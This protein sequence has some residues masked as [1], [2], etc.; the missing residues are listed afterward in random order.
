MNCRLR[1]LRQA[2]VHVLLT[3][4]VAVGVID[5][6]VG[7]AVVIVGIGRDCADRHAGNERRPPPVAP[8]AP[9]LRPARKSSQGRAEPRERLFGGIEVFEIAKI[10]GM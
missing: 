1:P 5:R 3:E 6:L 4:V 2:E 8:M 9:R 7:P 10:P